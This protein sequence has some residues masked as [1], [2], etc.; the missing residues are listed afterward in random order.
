MNPWKT[1]VTASFY[2]MMPHVSQLN[3]RTASTLNKYKQRLALEWWGKTGGMDMYLVSAMFLESWIL[4]TI[5][6]GRW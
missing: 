3:L 2:T 4:T 5:W 6:K 1:I